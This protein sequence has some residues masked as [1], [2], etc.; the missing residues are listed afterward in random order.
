MCVCVWACVS[1]Q[2]FVLIWDMFHENLNIIIIVMFPV[3]CYSVLIPGN[4]PADFLE[5]IHLL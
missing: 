4:T 3:K 5:S 2:F 1:T